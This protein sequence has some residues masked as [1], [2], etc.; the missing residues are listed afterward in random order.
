MIY[1]VRCFYYFH[2]SIYFFIIFSLLFFIIYFV[3]I[4]I[5]IFFQ[6]IKDK[7]YL[8]DDELILLTI[9][10]NMTY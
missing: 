6:W 7:E 8:V 4:D 10:Q 9:N 1:F 3:I 2:L 5:V